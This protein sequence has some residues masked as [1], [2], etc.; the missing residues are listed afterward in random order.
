MRRGAAVGCRGGLAAVVVAPR[1]SPHRMRD[2][3]GRVSPFPCAGPW[4]HVIG[5]AVGFYVGAKV[6]R[7]NTE[8][9]AVMQYEK[10]SI[11]PP[12]AWERTESQ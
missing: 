3:R 6:G 8:T 10:R 2:L 5:G 11:A 4:E 12:P 7:M 9:F 1:R